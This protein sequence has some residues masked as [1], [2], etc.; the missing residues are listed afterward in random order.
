MSARAFENKLFTMLS[1]SKLALVLVF[2]LILFS[3][4]GAVLPQQGQMGFRD[5]DFWQQA[6]PTITFI[7]RPVGAFQVFYSWPFIVTILILGLNTFT[8]TVLRFI[9]EG[10][11]SSLRGP[12]AVRRIG[13]LSLHLSLILLFAGGFLTSAMRMD[14]RILLTEGETFKERHESYQQLVEG[15]FRFKQHTDALIRLNNVRIDYEKKRYPVG[16]TTNI[17]IQPVG[18]NKVNGEIKVNQPFTYKGLSF[19]QDKTGYS[20]RLEIRHKKNRRSLLNSFVALRTFDTPGGKEYRD[21]L[22]LPFS[23]NRIIIE[24]YPSFSRDNGQIRKTGDEPEKPLLLIRIED[25]TSKKILQGNIPLGGETILGGYSFS[26]TDLRRW[27]A[28]TVVEDP[29]YLPVCI[30]LWV[31]LGALILRYIPDLKKWFI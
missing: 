16:I 25:E 18:G 19:T 13:F 24:V 9:K 28:F 12:G 4:V 8:C 3:I 22:R 30:S 14:A 23:K 5:I 7:L 31:G 26:F 11:F 6:H 15:P 1:S 20:P 21:F 10:G 27:S 17:D 29:G 2:L